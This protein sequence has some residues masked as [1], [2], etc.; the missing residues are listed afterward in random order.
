MSGGHR[1]TCRPPTSPELVASN[2]SRKSG[3]A[4][5]RERQVN[6]PLKCK[7]QARPSHCDFINGIGQKQTYAVQNG[8]F[9]LPPKADMCSAN[10][11]C[12]LW[13]KPGSRHDATSGFK[14]VERSVLLVL[15]RRRRSRAAHQQSTLG[16]YGRQGTTRSKSRRT[17]EA[18]G[19]MVHRGPWS[20]GR[21]T[22]TKGQTQEFRR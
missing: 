13:A 12:P 14:L 11:T 6:D 4:L 21:S 8:M 7:L 3:I 19:R 1:R 9:A 22:R 17:P 18:A 16:S 10:S 20:N 2:V 15:W 5:Q